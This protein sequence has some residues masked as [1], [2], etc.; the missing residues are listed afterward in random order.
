[1]AI[2]ESRQ[3]EIS[4]RMRDLIAGLYEDW[5][6]LDERIEAIGREIR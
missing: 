5:I 2:L 6:S 3:D 4:P 1:L